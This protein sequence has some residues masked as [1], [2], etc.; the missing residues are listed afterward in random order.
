MLRRLP[1]GPHAVREDPRLV[2]L[3]ALPLVGRLGPAPPGV[4]QLRLAVRPVL[5]GDNPLLRVALRLRASSRDVALVL[6]C[7]L[8][9]PATE[10]VAVVHIVPPLV[11]TS[12]LLLPV[13]PLAP[14]EVQLH[15]R[16]RVVEDLGALLPVGPLVVAHLMRA[17]GVLRVA[18]P[19]EVVRSQLRLGVVERLDVDGGR[20]ATEELGLKLPLPHQIRV[21]SIVLVVVISLVRGGGLAILTVLRLA[22]VLRRVGRRVAR[23]R[24]HARAEEDLLLLARAEDILLGLERLRAAPQVLLGVVA[25]HLGRRL[26]PSLACRNEPRAGGGSL[27]GKDRGGEGVVVALP[28]DALRGLA[29]RRHP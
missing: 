21:D 29:H 14:L 27:R 25:E 24:E 20:R 22:S 5:V 4:H 13:Q 6:L 17:M 26:V 7:L 2:Q 18:V 19:V 10:E 12:L 9:S 1:G 11:D 28:G 16:R 3:D 23:V 15:L 8:V